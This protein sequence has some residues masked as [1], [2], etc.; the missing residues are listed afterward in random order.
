MIHTIKVV[1]QFVTRV[2]ERK[3]FSKNGG[4]WFKRLKQFLQVLLY[5]EGLIA[6]LTD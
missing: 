4:G 6:V 2:H 3:M 1:S 5:L